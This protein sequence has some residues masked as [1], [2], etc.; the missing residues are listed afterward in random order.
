[1]RK[2][3]AILMAAS[4]ALAAAAWASEPAVLNASERALFERLERVLAEG[5]PSAAGVIETFG[6]P[7]D[8]A[9][10]MCDFNPSEA[11]SPGFAA[12]N[13][14]VTASGLILIL[15]RPRGQCIRADLAAAR[16]GADWIDQ[17]CHHAECW[18]RQAR[19]DWGILSF[20]V[21]TP[22]ARCV[23]SVV[24]NTLSSRRPGS[25]ARQGPASRLSL[26][27]LSSPHSTPPPRGSAP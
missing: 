27:R 23:T 9:G 4:G 20:G 2:L 17:S 13:L 8:C 5:N 6:L 21:D 25:G 26:S 7:P 3:I 14:R 18:Y 10:P 24:I 19:R 1:M 16:F 11:V 12:G 15:E 22:G